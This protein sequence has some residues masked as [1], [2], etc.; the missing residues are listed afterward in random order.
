MAARKTADWPAPAP[1]KPPPAA[2]ISTVRNRIEAQPSWRRAG[3]PDYGCADLVRVWEWQQC[4]HR[5][6]GKFDDERAAGQGGLRGEE[7]AEGQRVDSAGQRD[8]PLY[9]GVRG[10]LPRPD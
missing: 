1:T 9:Q 5:K 6:W 2:L 8:D 7:D 3:C 4:K 10:S